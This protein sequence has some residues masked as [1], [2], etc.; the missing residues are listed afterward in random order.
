MI[1]TDSTANAIPGVPPFDPQR[2]VD[3]ERGIEILKSIP[4]SSKGLDLEL[5]GVVKGVW[6]KGS[7]A[8]RS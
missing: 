8:W 5:R 3:G 4:V 1:P 7:L 2:S 6:D